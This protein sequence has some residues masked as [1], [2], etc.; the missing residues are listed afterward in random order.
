MTHAAAATASL[1]FGKLIL[2]LLF[3]GRDDVPRDK[4][5]FTHII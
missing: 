1:L 4:H 5:N 2:G 3:D